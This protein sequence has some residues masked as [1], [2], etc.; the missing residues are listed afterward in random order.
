[1]KS[2][3]LSGCLA[4]SLFGGVVLLTLLVNIAMFVGACFIVKWIFF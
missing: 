4:L 2:D 3:E 1:V